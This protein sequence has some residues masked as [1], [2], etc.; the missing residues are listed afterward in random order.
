MTMA[1]NIWDM[2]LHEQI[3]LS[4]KKTGAL[5]CVRVPGGWLY[6]L[7]IDTHPGDGKIVQTF[8]P[9]SDDMKPVKEPAETVVDLGEID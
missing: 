8:V 3:V 4:R 7:V 1:K 6:L 9:Y 5:A 2:K